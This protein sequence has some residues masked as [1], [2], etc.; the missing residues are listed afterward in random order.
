MKR[1]IVAAAGALLVLAA[2]MNLVEAKGRPA[3]AGAEGI[4]KASLHM[5]PEA[6]ARITLTDILV[7]GR[8]GV[9][10]GGSN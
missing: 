7:S 2:T 8:P 1:F 3:G 9:D 4:E 10:P 6:A 5:G